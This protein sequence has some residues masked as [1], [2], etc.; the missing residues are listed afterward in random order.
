M[1]LGAL[2]SPSWL[3]TPR[4]NAWRTGLETICRNAELLLAMSA[5]RSSLPGIRRESIVAFLY[6]R[7]ESV[8]PGVY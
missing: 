1:R 6:L 5:L 7:L 4:C 3:R 2:H 8:G